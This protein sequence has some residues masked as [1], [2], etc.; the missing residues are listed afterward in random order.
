M[1]IR[2]SLSL[3]SSSSCSA[4]AAERARCARIVA[5]GL[6]LGVVRQAAVFAFDTGMSSKAAVAALDAGRAD[7]TPPARRGLSERMQATTVPNPGSGG[8]GGQM[9]LAQKIVA[10]GKKRRGEA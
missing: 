6:R 1:C 2:D 3:S 5:H 10:A 7:Q 8:G 9:T 4:R